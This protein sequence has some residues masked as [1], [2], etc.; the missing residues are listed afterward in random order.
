MKKIKLEQTTFIV[1]IRNEKINVTLFYQTINCLYNQF[2]I[3][4]VYDLKND[5]SIRELIKINKI[6]SRIKFVFSK[7]AGVKKSITCALNQVKSKFA[8]I[9]LADDLG[10]IYKLDEVIYALQKNPNAIISAT[11]Y[12]KGGKRM[13]GSTIEIIFSTMANFIFKIIYNLD[14]ATTAFRFAK[15]KLLIK[16]YNETK[17]NDWSINLEI[18]FIAKKNGTPIIFVPVI[19][20]DRLRF[21]ESTFKLKTWLLQYISIFL[22]KLKGGYH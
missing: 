13:F 1:P 15:T 10:I 17:N 11:R 16:A 21:G 14:D 7:D 2:N 19:S 3:I 5:N 12:T 22:K 20:I 6:D 4:F 8:G 9:L 18:S